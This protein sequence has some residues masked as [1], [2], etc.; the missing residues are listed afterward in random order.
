[1]SH[2]LVVDDRSE[3][4][5]LLKAL[6]EAYD[7]TVDQ[8][9]NGAEAIEIARSTKPALVISDL[10][11]PVMDGYTLL[12]EWRADPALRS[13]PFIVYTATYTDPRDERLALDLGA[14][15]FIVKPADPE[16][17]M[18]RV[19]EVLDIARVP[20]ATREAPPE[21]TTFRMYSEVLVRK[22]EERTIQLEER[23]KE[24]A[25]S[26]Q[27]I[28]RLSR[29]YAALS[30]TNQAIVHLADRVQLFEA[31][32]RIAVERGGMK[33]AWIGLVDAQSR[34]IVPLAWNGSGGQWFSQMRPFRANG[35]PRTPV[36]YAVAGD[37]VFLS[38]DLE[39]DSSVAPI[40]GILREAGL[41]AAI[42]L[43]LRVNGRVVG[44][45]T[46]FAGEK[47][48]FYDR[49][50]DLVMEIAHDVSFALENF[51]KESRLRA[52]LEAVRL[53][54]RAVEASANGIMISN[55][56]DG[57]NRITYVNPAFTRITGYTA[58]EALGRDPE[59]LMGE[60]TAQFGV[61]EIKTAMREQREGQ[62]VLRNYRKDGGLFWNELSIAP[63]RDAGGQATHFVGVINDITDRK[64]Y[65][66]QL[67][68][69]NNQDALT[70]L[71]SRNLLRDRVGQAI[72]YAAGH[73]RFI[74]LLFLDIDDFKRINDSL[75]HEPGDT[76]LRTV[77]QRIT[78]CVRDR[79][80]VARL[81]GDD[82]VIVLSDLEALQEVPVISAAILHAIERPIAVGTREINVTASIGVS[83][84]PQD[85]ADYDTLLR[86]ADTAMYSAKEAGR[87]TFRFYAAGM[88]E[89]ALQRLE[90]ES[91]L[92]GAMARNELLLHYQPLVSL[93]GRPV[94]NMEA[95]LRW[96]AADGSLTPPAAF[97][98]VAEQT[99]LIMAIGEWVLNTACRQAR[100]WQEAGHE[101]RVGVNL[102]ARQF[103]D[104]NLVAITRQCL[105]ESGL[106]PRLLRLEIT[107]STVMDN[108]EEA[109]VVLEELKALGVFLSVD[110]FGTGYSSL[111]YLRRFPID[112]LKIDQ[113]FVHDIHHP[114]SAAIVLG[115]IGLARNLR[116]Q[117]VAEGVETPEQRDF[118]DGAGCDLM[119]GYLF[120]H[121]KPAAELQDLIDGNGPRRT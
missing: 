57:E 85:G 110:D 34:E 77:A 13:V 71:A 62:A 116:L 37:R 33:L 103:R 101:L 63:V 32:C 7:F 72:A 78:G 41:R 31:V 84:F 22:L 67:E 73:G 91:R 8:A 54:S 107:E 105:R 102:S 82:F 93:D 96:R 121:P 17:F 106:P 38:N 4:L 51:E 69:Q 70:G 1:M 18:R 60:E 61:A 64:Q 48:Y 68:M 59:F 65:E 43:P 55:R 35:I 90:L 114:D 112:Q 100:A 2:A 23:V 39:E 9:H 19:H 25:R 66:E 40:L 58:D 10:M 44:A 104:R 119:Q 29:L 108:A 120:S 6:L 118:L 16:I 27:Q 81:G 75:G 80:T 111:A 42:S 109:A 5:G 92:H 15:A 79:D 36:E 86:N 89:A 95:L 94:A 83:V 76:I 21:E 12:R 74:A 117:T 30:E 87:N 14:D 20:V 3:N 115:I 47:D 53:N 28:T 50:R 45:L 56:L 97:I 52:S 11:M 46:L 24:L 98:P 88:N 49:L 26:E 113:S 99:G